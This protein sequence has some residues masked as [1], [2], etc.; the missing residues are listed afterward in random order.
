[1]KNILWLFLIYPFLAFG[2]DF[3]TQEYMDPENGETLQ[4]FSVDHQQMDVLKLYQKELRRCNYSFEKE[5]SDCRAVKG[6]ESLW[7]DKFIP[8]CIKANADG[9]YYIFF[10]RKLK[11]EKEIYKA[12]YDLETN[13]V[14]ELQWI[15]TI[16]G[17]T[18][19]N[20]A[21]CNTRFFSSNNDKYYALVEIATKVP[22]V[23]QKGETFMSVL[24]FDEQFN[25]ISS[26]T[27]HFD[28]APF[29]VGIPI[30]KKPFAQPYYTRAIPYLSNDGTFFY[31]HKTLGE[32][33]LLSA[34]SDEEHATYTK[35]DADM[36]N[37]MKPFVNRM[38]AEGIEFWHVDTNIDEGF[39]L[40][41]QQSN[42]GQNIKRSII[43]IRMSSMNASEWKYPD[44]YYSI[45]VVTETKSG[46]T[47]INISG[48]D[49]SPRL[50]SSETYRVNGMYLFE[51]I[52]NKLDLIHFHPYK[53]KI[54]IPGGTVMGGFPLA[55]NIE[56]N[57]KVLCFYLQAKSKDY[58]YKNKY[59]KVKAIE[60]D[61]LTEDIQT[62]QMDVLTKN[63][64]DY[65][66]FPNIYSTKERELSIIELEAMTWGNNKY[67]LLF[68]IN[69]EKVFRM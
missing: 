10:S 64:G 25:L 7:K 48:L 32:Y 66:F 34:A 9:I 45:N 57:N 63:Y 4:I 51:L 14:Q 6:F 52:N 18:H 13:E 68:P 15:E 44:N 31:L 11:Q 37:T 41:V 8:I 62:F 65:G 28:M 58:I 46:R 39:Q 27:S 19:L 29:M 55:W 26:Q 40:V 12:V 47:I 22:G 21:D 50:T 36:F 53:T 69:I 20:L 61:L 24:F 30:K 3:N 38:A 54:S 35:Y 2:Q 42:G 49:N 33:I 5:D 23:L 56:S 1:M 43:P 67:I 16:R 59:S 60:F 17:Y